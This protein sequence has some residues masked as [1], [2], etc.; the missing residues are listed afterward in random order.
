MQQQSS[1]GGVSWLVTEIGLSVRSFVDVMVSMLNS[2]I[3]IS[4][5]I[6]ITQMNYPW[7]EADLIGQR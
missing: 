7:G 6:H 5:S 1:C 3:L 4:K 2:L